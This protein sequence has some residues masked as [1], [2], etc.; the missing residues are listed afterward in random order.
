M[1]GAGDRHGHDHDHDQGLAHDLARLLEAPLERRRCLGLIAAGGTIAA[2]GLAGR[3]VPA[4]AAGPGGGSRCVAFPEETAGPFPANGSRGWSGSP[5]DVLGL[6]GIVR[7]D[8]RSSFAGRRGRAAGVPVTLTLHLAGSGRG[9]APLA[10]HAVYLWQCDAAGRYSLYTVPSENYLRGV[11]ATDGQGRATFQTIFP[12]AYDGRFP[13][14]HF[15]VYRSIA[16]AGRHGRPLLTSQLAM[17]RATADAVYRG[18]G[19]Y[20][21]SAA[22]LRTMDIATDY[23]FGDNDKGEMAAMTLAMTGSVA[24]GYAATAVVGVA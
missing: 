21:A 9:C 3:M 22:N 24:T 13:H 6:S 8:I 16:E 14:M 19:V 2:A 1:R 10:G 4:A 20:G 15:Q 12:A 23:V 5:P 17:P 18:A 11:Q 7:R